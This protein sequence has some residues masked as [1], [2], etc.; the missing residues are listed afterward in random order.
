MTKLYSSE[1]KELNVNYLLKIIVE[2]KIFILIVTLFTTLFSAYWAYSLD[3]VYESEGLLKIGY[4]FEID[5]NGDGYEHQLEGAN[6]LT[7]QLSFMFIGKGDKQASIVEIT[8]E[9]PVGQY[10]KIVS[11]G[12]TPEDSSNAI[13]N[14]VR[15]VQNEHSRSIFNNRKKHQ[16]T[17]NDLVDRLSAITKN[18]QRFLSKEEE[19]SYESKDYEL[20]FFKIQLMKII[21]VELGDDYIS[22]ILQRKDRIEL[23]LSE[24][25]FEQN[26]ALLGEIY[27]SDQPIKP[28]KKII[29]FFGFFA[30]ILLSGAAVIFRELFSK[31][32]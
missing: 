1:Y 24:D 9:K 11:E 29:V 6:E 23:L 21:D 4:Y 17:F 2:S 12:I 8:P 22:Q 14:L 27:T 13:N 3:P 5:V 28:R 26:T 18:Q 30:G 32:H 16:A 10:I 20:L 7:T 25:K 31:Q 15:Y 19:E